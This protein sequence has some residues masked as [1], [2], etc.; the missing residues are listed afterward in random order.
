MVLVAACGG[1]VVVDAAAGGG[2]AGGSASGA[3]GSTSDAGVTCLGGGGAAPDGFKACSSDADCTLGI[4]T[5]CCGDYLLGVAKDELDAF[6]AYEHACNHGPLCNCGGPSH[7]ED[8]KTGMVAVSCQMG[9]CMS[10]V[11]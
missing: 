6:E 7:A 4:W 10:F 8:G 3:G 11:P 1:K 5:A 2:G 9:R